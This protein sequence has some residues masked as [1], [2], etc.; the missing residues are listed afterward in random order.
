MDSIP[1]Q[2][3]LSVYS[4][5]VNEPRI[6]SS[7]SQAWP[8]EGHDLSYHPGKRGGGRKIAQHTLITNMVGICDGFYMLGLGSGTIRRCGPVGVG[9]SLCRL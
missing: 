6:T 8:T 1:S 7:H 2:E 4:V 3:M 9:M 5:S